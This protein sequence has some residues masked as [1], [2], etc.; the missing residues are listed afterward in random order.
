MNPAPYVGS[1]GTELRAPPKVQSVSESFPG[2]GRYTING[3]INIPT[4]NVRQSPKKRQ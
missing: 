2:V 4:H 1:F 3:D